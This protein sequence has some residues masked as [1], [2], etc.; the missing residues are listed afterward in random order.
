MT[1]VPRYKTVRKVLIIGAWSL[2]AAGSI[3]LLVAAVRRQNQALCKGVRITI[4]GSG[5][6]MVDSSELRDILTDQHTRLLVGTPAESISTRRLERK[7]SASPWVKKAELFFDS[8]QVLW[9]KVTEREPVARLF[10]S[11]GQSFYMDTAGVR[12][13]LKDYFPVKLPVFTSCP[14]DGK[15]WNGADTLLA[16]EVGVLS[17]YLVAHPFWMDMVQQVDVTP[18]GEFDLVPTIGDNEIKL[19]DT[20][21][22]DSKF[23]RLMVFYRDI[24]PRVGWNKY[25]ALDVRFAGQVVGVKRDAKSQAI[26]TAQASA[27]LKALI[28]Q[29]RSA[30]QDT[31]VKTTVTPRNVTPDIDSTLDLVPSDGD[32]GAGTAAGP[33]GVAPKAGARS[34]SGS[35]VKAGAPKG[36][37]PKAGPPSKAGAKKPKAVMPPK[38][39]RQ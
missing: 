13:P 12:L 28:D 3:T 21:A 14:L 33:A 8:K 36:R 26:D 7:I 29:G 22:L 9:V 11:G 1:I 19:G 34:K 25:A 39:N 5:R 24:L 10:T 2:V 38:P 32:Q 18:E 27:L 31:L 20:S 23:R 17:Q 6:W 37:P 4:E 35:P 30:M 15:A 16:R